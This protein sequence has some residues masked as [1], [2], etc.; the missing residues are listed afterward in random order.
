MRTIGQWQAMFHELFAQAYGGYRCL[1][2]TTNV[3]GFIEDL[4]INY[5]RID[6]SCFSGQLDGIEWALVDCLVDLFV[7]CDRLDIELDR[8]IATK[9]PGACFY[10]G[11]VKDCDCVG[12]HGR[13]MLD[14]SL[15][16]DLLTKSL[17]DWQSMLG[18]LFGISNR[19]QGLVKVSEHLG[20]EITEL[21]EAVVLYVASPNDATKL[22]ASLE[23]A[24]VLAWLIAIANLLSIDLSSALSTAYRL[25]RCPSCEQ[26]VC[27]DEAN[28]PLYGWSRFS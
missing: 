17:H 4:Q 14:P 22:A 1:V 28:C 26:E 21:A 10:C 19:A 23:C 9:W 18:G 24:D 11:K 25:D 5:P 15:R 8:S 7:I 2:K 27:K 3:S 12:K 6:D 16:S 20:K 13:P